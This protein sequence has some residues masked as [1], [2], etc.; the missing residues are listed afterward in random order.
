[1]VISVKDFFKEITWRSLKQ[2]NSEYQQNPGS[3]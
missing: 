1:M 2:G 3:R